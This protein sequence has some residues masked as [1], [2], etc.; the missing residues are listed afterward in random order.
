M[1]IYLYGNSHCSLGSGPRDKHQGFEMRVEMGRLFFL[2][3]IFLAGRRGPSSP[4]PKGVLRTEHGQEDCVMEVFGDVDGGRSSSGP[5]FLK[6]DLLSTP[7]T[8]HN[9]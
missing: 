4:M 1:L 6:Y 9:S 3:C 7:S 8:R 2:K 5:R